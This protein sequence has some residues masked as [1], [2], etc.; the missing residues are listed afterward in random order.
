MRK[1]FILLLI[2]SAALIGACEDD[3]TPPTTQE[4]G[5]LSGIVED[6]ETGEPIAG[7]LVEAVVS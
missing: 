2:S 4:Y 3:V 7:A 6:R 5:S 1:Q